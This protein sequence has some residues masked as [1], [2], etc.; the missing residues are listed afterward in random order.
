MIQEQQTSQKIEIDDVLEYWRS[1]ATALSID[2]GRLMARIRELEAELQER[3]APPEVI[4][5]RAN[6]VPAV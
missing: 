5:T 6:N 4:P 3:S 1:M 2:R